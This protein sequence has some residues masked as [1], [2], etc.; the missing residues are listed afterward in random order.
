MLNIYLAVFGFPRRFSSGNSPCVREVYSKPTGQKNQTSLVPVTPSPPRPPS[1][2]ILP[3]SRQTTNTKKST[4]PA[5]PDST[6]PR[7]IM[8]TVPPPLY[9][10]YECFEHP[11][12]FNPLTR[13]LTRNLYRQCQTPGNVVA[14]PSLHSRPFPSRV[15]PKQDHPKPTPNTKG[16]CLSPSLESIPELVQ[17]ASPKSN[18]PAPPSLPE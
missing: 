12:I 8:S 18:R 16:R 3:S 17:N 1:P 10:G 5:P 11:S 4:K 15:D 13:R 7:S 14:F 6:T 9:Q 2:H